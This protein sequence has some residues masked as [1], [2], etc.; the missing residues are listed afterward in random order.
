MARSGAV[1]VMLTVLDIGLEPELN[2]RV[3][4]QL[5]I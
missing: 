4:V 1:S 3:S 5:D 2:P